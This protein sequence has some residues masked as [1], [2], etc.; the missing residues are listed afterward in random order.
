MSKDRKDAIRNHF[1]DEPIHITSIDIIER[2]NVI[3]VYYIKEDD[4]K[5]QVYDPNDATHRRYKR[6]WRINLSEVDAL[7]KMQTRNQ[8]ITQILQ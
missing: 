2:M 3:F 1:F 8:K 4:I 7:I 6:R 5:D